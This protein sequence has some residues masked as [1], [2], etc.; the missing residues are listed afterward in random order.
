MDLQ[1]PRMDGLELTRRIKRDPAR[2][3]LI[4]VALTAYATPDDRAR[5]VDAGCDGY[6]SKP[7]D[8]DTLLQLV[9]DLLARAAPRAGA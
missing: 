7:L 2:H 5:A 6:L 1:L 9:A 8:I 4:I 3:H